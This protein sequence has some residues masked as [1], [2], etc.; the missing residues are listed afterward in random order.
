[1]EGGEQSDQGLETCNHVCTYCCISKRERESEKVTN[2]E[3]KKIFFKKKRFLYQHL[4]RP[5]NNA[6]LRECEKD[7]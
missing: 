5:L 3:G 7:R 2:E 6:H 4:I 1:M